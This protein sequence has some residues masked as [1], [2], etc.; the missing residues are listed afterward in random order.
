MEWHRW[1]ILR[2]DCF[3]RKGVSREEG[4]ARPGA[5]ARRAPPGRR[6]A[7]A[8]AAVAIAG[9]A[10]ASTI[11]GLSV[12]A[13]NA[14]DGSFDFAWEYLDARDD[15]ETVLPGFGVGT[16]SLEG[17]DQ[18]GA[19]PT[20]LTFGSTGVTGVT[21]VLTTSGSFA[22]DPEVVNTELQGQP[23]PNGQFSRQATENSPFLHTGLDPGQ[24][25]AL[26][27]AV[28]QS[29][30]VRGFGFSI[31]DLGDFG[32]TVVVEFAGGACVSMPIAPGSCGLRSSD[33]EDGDHI[34]VGFTTDATIANVSIE[35]SGGT[36]G[37]RFG[38][39]EFTV[40][41][42]PV[43]P[44]VGLAGLGLVAVAAWRRRATAT[45]ARRPIRP[46]RGRHRRT[47]RRSRRAS[48]R[49]GHRAQGDRSS[50]DRMYGC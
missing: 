18:L 24:S 15:F 10:T 44:A 2:T 42:V 1:I 32:A 46:P 21:G 31:T 41:V 50:I 3:C 20:D 45:V 48:A 49:R 23:D 28:D 9:T 13:S 14:H 22:F 5:C 38:F 11:G 19:P 6:E 43:P 36:G 40:L 17:A 4:C 27:I 7:T 37:D 34:R 47:D 26:M 29:E 8:T 30:A 35:M 12:G 25:G 33:F 16:D 39:D